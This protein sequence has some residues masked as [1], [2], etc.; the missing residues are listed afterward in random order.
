MSGLS[1]IVPAYGRSYNSLKALESDFNALKDFKTPMGQA[2]NKTDLINEGL[3]SIQVRYG[4]N[5]T[6]TAVLN[7]N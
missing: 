5:L 6:K 2:I 3:K 7:I 1:P 4:K